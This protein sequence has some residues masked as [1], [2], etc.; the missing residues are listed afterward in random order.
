MADVQSI[1]SRITLANAP[2]IASAATAIATNPARAAWSIQNLG[3]AP[4]YVLLATGAS[5]T[6]FHFA[7]KAGSGND[8]GTGGIAMQSEGIVYTGIITV[9]S[10]GTVRYTTWEGT[11]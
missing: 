7:L 11:V 1:I 2:T 10:S 9:A 5:T 4:L 6:V 8:D 3:T